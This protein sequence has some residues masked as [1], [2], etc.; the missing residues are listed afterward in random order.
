MPCTQQPFAIR[1]QMANDIAY[2]RRRKPGIHHDGQIME[3][4][5]GF[6]VAAPDMDMRRF[7]ALI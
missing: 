3:P 2:F 1:S 6:H 4:E 5:F 7:T